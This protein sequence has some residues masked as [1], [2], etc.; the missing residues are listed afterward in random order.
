MM[1]GNS[2]RLEEQRA[3][4][5]GTIL[6]TMAKIP[7]AQTAYL[8][9]IT[10]FLSGRDDWISTHQTAMISNRYLLHGVRATN[11]FDRHFAKR[12]TVDLLIIDD[13]A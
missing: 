13:F 3:I 6:G 12:A 11:A 10:I 2:L 1:E 7:I 9:E 4:K 8:F 5:I